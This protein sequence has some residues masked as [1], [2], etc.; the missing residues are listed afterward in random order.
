MA[1][2]GECVRSITRGRGDAGVGAAAR[3]LGQ[4]GDAQRSSGGHIAE[5]CRHADGVTAV[6]PGNG[7]EASAHVGDAATHHALHRHDLK[8]D[9]DISGRN[10]RCRWHDSGGRLDAGD[11]AAMRRVAQ[12]SAE[13]VAEA[14]WAHAC[15]DCGRLA[16]A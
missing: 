3:W 6:D 1:H 13:V 4:H 9:R 5:H 2:V 11:A 8:R 15:G 7:S 12:G 16:A 14:E 10:H